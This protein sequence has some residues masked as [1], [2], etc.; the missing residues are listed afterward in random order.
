MGLEPAALRGSILSEASRV[1]PVYVGWPLTAVSN[2]ILPIVQAEAIGTL[3]RLPL[4]AIAALRSAAKAVLVPIVLAP[5][6]L[7]KEATDVFVEAAQTVASIETACSLLTRARSLASENSR[8]QAATAAFQDVL[9]PA[10]E[11]VQALLLDTQGRAEAVNRLVSAVEANDPLAV[12]VRRL[13]ETWFATE[14]WQSI[15]TYLDLRSPAMSDLREDGL[16]LTASHEA[17]ES[18]INE[19]DQLVGLQS[20]KAQVRT[21]TN[22]LQ[23]RA[24]RA[25]LGLKVAATTNHMVFV[26]PPG[27]GKTTV[28]R[29]LG[30][31]FHALGLLSRGEVVEVARQDLVAAYIGQTAL[32]T[33]AVIDSAI[34]SVL[35]IDEAYSLVREQ[36]PNDLGI[37]AIETLLK[38]MEDDRDKFILIVAG[39]KNEM[40]RFL[41]ANPGLK[42]RFSETIS[43][44]DYSPEELFLIFEGFVRSEGYR[45]AEGATRKAQRVL[46][47]AWLERDA[48]FANARLVRNFFEDTLAQHAN[49]LAGRSDLDETVLSLLEENDIPDSP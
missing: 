47:A 22:M 23:I 31:I 17:L 27:T 24:K 32:K 36:T 40:E 15:E 1:A 44:P 5:T 33:N 19:L 14:R 35:F 9:L 38:R 49:R 3:S 2:A 4:D 37:E 6:D 10:I 11:R 45:L 8:R 26:G 16:D 25:E 29:L 42:D 46:E 7:D 21:I 41:S 18:L 30:Q 28:A 48:N 13:L 39:Y 34:G 20:V 43:F 12:E